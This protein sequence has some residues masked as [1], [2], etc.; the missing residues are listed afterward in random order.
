M[1][2]FLSTSTDKEEKKKKK[3]YLEKINYRR[4]KEKSDRKMQG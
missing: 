4:K 3:T 1:F 2:F